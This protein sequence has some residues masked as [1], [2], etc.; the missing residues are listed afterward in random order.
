MGVTYECYLS[1]IS[2]KLRLIRAKNASDGLRGV[3][4]LMPPR[5][6]IAQIYKYVFSALFSLWPK[7][8]TLGRLPERFGA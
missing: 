8:K 1:F 3:G 5:R 2:F 4:T 6:G 7:Y